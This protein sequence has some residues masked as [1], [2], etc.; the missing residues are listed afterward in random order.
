M[1]TDAHPTNREFYQYLL[2]RDRCVK[3][4]KVVTHNCRYYG[5]R[6]LRPSAQRLMVGCWTDA[7][8]TI[9][10]SMFHSVHLLDKTNSHSVYIFTISE[11]YFLIEIVLYLFI[12]FF[13][14]IAVNAEGFVNI[15]HGG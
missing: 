1:A 7:V 13:L 3:V 6:L 5:F 12:G 2:L 8:D 4:Q 15:S 14:V 11:R 9:V 10:L